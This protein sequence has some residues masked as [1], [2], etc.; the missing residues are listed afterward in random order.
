MVSYPNGRVPASALTSVARGVQLLNPVASAY[1]AL[2]RVAAFD[3]ITVR[4]AAGVGSGYRSLA[5]QQLFYQAG[6]GDKAAAEKV[7]LSGTSSVAVAAPGYSS[8]GTG[9]RVD[10]VFDGSDDPRGPHLELAARYG[11]TR[12]FG[13]RDRNH[14]AHDVKT[15]IHGIRDHDK[16][17]MIGKY[18]NNRTLA[19]EK[20]G[21][22][23]S[24][25]RGSFYWT[26]IQE[27]GRKD[28]IYPPPYLID[29]DP[30]RK[31]GKPSLTRKLENHYWSLILH[32]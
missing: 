4:P 13:T 2:I 3:G 28:G 7:G 26:R 16:V 5:I 18:L 31:D 14:F 30:N 24:G 15:G 21:A 6:N 32:G 27:A 10:L 23:K 8:H 22:E 11:F 19:G 1:G 29:G 12:E 20:T 9:T 17:R 25:E